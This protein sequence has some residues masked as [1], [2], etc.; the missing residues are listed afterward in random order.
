MGY[1][2]K[3]GYLKCI[4]ILL[5]FTIAQ[6]L[7]PPSYITHAE[8]YYC[9]NLPLNSGIVYDC[10]YPLNAGGSIEHISGGTVC[11]PHAGSI[12]N[13]CGE[14]VDT[15][16]HT[17]GIIYGGT[18]CMPSARI[19][20]IC[21]GNYA[22]CPHSSGTTYG[23]TICMPSARICNICNGDYSK[24][25]HSSGQIYGGT[26]CTPY[27]GKICNIC[28]KN[29]SG[30]PHGTGM[31]YQTVCS[32][33]SEKICNICNSKFSGCPHSEG[34]YYYGQ[35]CSPYVGKVCNICSKNYSG[36][37]H[38]SGSTY[39]AVCSPFSA[40]LCNLCNANYIGCPHLTGTIYGGK[41][42]NPSPSI[43][44]IDHQ[45]FPGC[46]HTGGQLVGGTV[47]NPSPSFCNICGGNNA[48]CLHYAGQ[49]YGG[50]EC[51][52]SPGTICNICGSNFSHCSHVAGETYGGIK[53]PAT[54]NTY[55]IHNNS[56][57]FHYTSHTHSAT[58]N[59]TVNIDPNIQHMIDLYK[60][61]TNGDYYREY[62]KSANDNAGLPNAGVIYNVDP[63][64]QFT[65]FVYDENI[66]FQD[67]VN[68]MGPQW[69]L[70][71]ENRTMSDVLRDLQL[72]IDILGAVFPVMWCGTTATNMGIDIMRGDK[73]A[74][75][76][77]A[78][79]LVLVYVGG[80]IVV[81]VAGKLATRLQGVTDIPLAKQM[82][83]GAAEAEEIIA[84]V[85]EER[86]LSLSTR[87]LNQSDPLWK[88]AANIKPIEGYQDII[89]HGDKLG[90]VWKDAN[91][92]ESTVSINEFAEILKSSPVYKGGPIRLISCETGADD[93][94]AAQYLAK[95]LGVEVIAPSD[96]VYVYEDGTMKIGINNTGTWN[97]FKP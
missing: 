86:A 54:P 4:C 95:N 37:P 27:D 69:Q 91:G 14:N 36:C 2:V 48:T 55:H 23:G 89:C 24:C 63:I 82:I 42:C 19:C 62:L 50:T 92:V 46:G 78:G 93:A 97:I 96:I 25:P 94:I 17:P 70:A 29:Y 15:C 13:I 28:V 64:Q 16:P 61:S 90:F 9:N 57:A 6:I 32:P 31:T 67:F 41:V 76:E 72:S 88:N 49:L 35:V 71:W 59:G 30:C 52:T 34:S 40:K 73:V 39:S 12:C 56:C 22:T 65:T 26:T 20:N 79:G 33:Y 11:S 38:K 81:K 58:C 18:V 60:K 10:G 43:C 47:C 87:F 68:V 3:K 66:T 84:E 80:R 8:T 53:V 74:A 1:I 5:L 44:N 83:N 21:N 75:L 77:R 85:G 7:L 51:T 45:V